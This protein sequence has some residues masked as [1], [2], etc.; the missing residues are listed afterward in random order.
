MFEQEFDNVTSKFVT[1]SPRSPLGTVHAVS[2]GRTV[3]R[4][5]LPG[6][7]QHIYYSIDEANDTIVIHTIWGARRGRSPKL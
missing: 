1:M 2:H 4:V 5:L 6:T 3:W 7:Q